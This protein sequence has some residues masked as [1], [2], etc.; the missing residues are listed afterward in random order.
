MWQRLGLLAAGILM[1]LL[2]TG[3]LM[4]LTARPPGVPVQLHPP[5]TE[6]PC[7][8]HVAGA[9]ALP[10]VY[11]LPRGS[12]VRDAIAA[13]G[14]LSDVSAPESLNLAAVLHDHQKIVVPSR[15]A[16]STATGGDP[17][18]GNHQMG[19]LLNLNTATDAEL[20]S[21]PGIGPSLAKAI[22]AF[23]EA[24]GPFGTPD[25]L[26]DVPGIGPAKLAGLRDLVVCE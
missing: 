4:V 18:A 13:A 5:P 9:V 21:L 16:P 1:G 20:D 8:V 24:H 6:G 10:G 23:R 25:E 22:V 7:Q 3:L 17:G 19:G 11:S 15:T 2:A 12:L 14:G 26:L